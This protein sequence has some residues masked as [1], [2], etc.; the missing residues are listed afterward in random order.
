MLKLISFGS[1]SWGNSYILSDESISIIIDCGISLRR[2]KKLYKDYGISQNTLR[3]ALITHD[4]TDHVKAVGKVSNEF[5]LPVYTTEKIHKGIQ[6]NYR[7]ATKVNVANIKIVEK[8]QQFN[9]GEFKITP[10]ALPHDSSENVG[11]CIEYQNIVFTIMTDIG[12]ATDNVAIYIG[13]STHLVIESN[14]DT[15]MLMN[16]KYTA[17]LKQ[18]IMGGNGHL[19]NDQTGMALAANYH[20]SLKQVWLCHL[21]EENNL[22]ETALETVVKHMK[23]SGIDTDKDVSIIPL[24]RKTPTGPFFF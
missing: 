15:Q 1:G 13:K 7:I 22:P 23:Q 24:K 9:I 17:I 3:A 14:Y 12:M 4:H 5:H 10:F 8:D 18:R 19:S 20:D 21:S 2:I 11:Y 16:G 6:T